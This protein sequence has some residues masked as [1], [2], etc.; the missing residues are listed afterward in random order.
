MYN[1]VYNIK[2]IH[3]GTSCNHEGNADEE[4]EGYIVFKLYIHGISWVRILK[5]IPF[6][7]GP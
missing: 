7:T 1:T 3:I 5:D 2:C 6:L 4:T